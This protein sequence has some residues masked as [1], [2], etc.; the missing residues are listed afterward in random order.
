MATA[1]QYAQWIVDNQS[2]KGTEKFNI[3]A[4]AYQEAKGVEPVAEAKPIMQ[5]N[6]VWQSTGGGAAVGKPT[7]INRTNV[8]PEPRPLESALAG[9][10][11]S[12]VDLPVGAA[13]LAT[14]GN[15]G[16]SQLAQNLGK[17]SE[18]Y[19]QANPM[20]YGAGRVVGAVGPA[21]AGGGAIGAI[22]SFTKMGNLGQNLALGAATGALTP[23][24]TGKTGAEL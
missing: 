22:P 11:K 1:D 23:E 4:Q 14:G 3:V 2:L 21:I 20:S 10:T 17:Q 9:A 5:E 13:Q 12:L 16:T 6:P 24:E 18:V 15:L 19:S 8:L 7:L